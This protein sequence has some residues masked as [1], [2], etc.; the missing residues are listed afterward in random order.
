MKVICIH[1]VSKETKNIYGVPCA[2]QD[3]IYEGNIYNK[4]NEIEIYGKIFYILE[5]M[6]IGNSYVE[7][8]FIPLSEIDELQLVNEKLQEA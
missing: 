2:S 7:S 4:I 5:N 6:P 1:G 8:R 3:E